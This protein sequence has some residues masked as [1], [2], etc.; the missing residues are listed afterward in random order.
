[1]V[2]KESTPDSDVAAIMERGSKKA[3]LGKGNAACSSDANLRL[4]GK[5]RLSR[6]E[7]CLV[8]TDVRWNLS[9]SDLLDMTPIKARDLIVECFY[10]AQKETIGAAGKKLGQTQ[11]DAEL[12]DTVTGAVRLACREAA[13]DFDH[14]TKH[15][16]MAAVQI[17]ARKS[18][19]WGTPADIVEHHKG[20]IERVLQILD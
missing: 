20:Q 5:T 8:K 9:D 6:Q 3:L 1:L 12:R 16:L 18:Q 11:D 15:G 4:Q 13:A 2:F 10:Q 19:H 14:P 7:R 17:L